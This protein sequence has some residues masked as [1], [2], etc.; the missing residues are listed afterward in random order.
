MA[1]QTGGFGAGNR[2]SIDIDMFEQKM[3]VTVLKK[4]GDDWEE[5][6]SVLFAEQTCW[7]NPFSL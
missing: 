6:G 3:S 5:T 4:N 1:Q 7:I 2:I